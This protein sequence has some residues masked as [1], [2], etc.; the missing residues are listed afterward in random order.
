MPAFDP[1]EDILWQCKWHG[2]VEAVQALSILYLLSLLSSHRDAQSAGGRF[3]QNANDADVFCGDHYFWA[4]GW[5]CTSANGIALASVQLSLS[6][7]FERGE[8][9]VWRFCRCSFRCGEW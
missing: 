6:R 1:L 4:Y 9:A 7:S 5:C 3:R 8:M 2:T